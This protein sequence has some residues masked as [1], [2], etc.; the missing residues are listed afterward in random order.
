MELLNY[1]S[2]IK[3]RGIRI[4]LYVAGDFHVGAL[5]CDHKL[6]ERQIRCVEKDENGYLIGMGDYAECI[7]TK[8]K[9]FDANSIHPRFRNNPNNL[10]GKQYDYVRGLLTPLASEGRILCVL[11]GNHEMKMAHQCQF[12]F[13]H[14]LCDDLGIQYGGYSCAIVWAF[15]RGKHTK[16]IILYANHGRGGAARTKGGK[17]NT[18]MKMCEIIDNADIYLSAHVHEKA[19]ERDSKLDIGWF[20][21]GRIVLKQRK[22]AYGTT[23]A[24][25]RTYTEGSSSYAERAAY[26]PTDLGMIFVEIQSESIKRIDGK[27]VNVPKIDVRDL[28]DY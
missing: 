15:K 17:L 8:D 1:T 13:V 18:L 22:V 25:L 27:D 4:R 21:N 23:G 6:L 7:N 10:I 20:K 12:S 24:F 11:E 5:G 28:V 16:N 26:S 9:R 3:N 14:Q 2:V 19:T